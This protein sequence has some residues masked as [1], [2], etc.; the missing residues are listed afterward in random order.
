[1]YL[2]NEIV[3]H[4]LELHLLRNQEKYLP[5]QLDRTLVYCLILLVEISQDS[6]KQTVFPNSLLPLVRG[7]FCVCKPRTDDTR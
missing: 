2:T 6:E 4:C 7:I 1:M 3:T 5:L